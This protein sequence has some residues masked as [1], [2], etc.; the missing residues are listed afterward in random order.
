[1]CLLGLFSLSVL[2]ALT[3]VKPQSGQGYTVSGNP[4]GQ[5]L[6]P[7]EGGRSLFPS[8]LAMR[9]IGPRRDEGEVEEKGITVALGGGV[10]LEL[11][12]IPAGVFVMGS[13]ESEEGRDKDEGP[14][15]W[16]EITRP[17]YLGRYEVT[18]EQ[19]RKVM[20]HNP[21]GFSPTGQ[22][23]IEVPGMNTDHFPVESVSWDDAERFCDKL[24]ERDRHRRR[25]R[26]PT[27][28][29]W[30]YACRAGTSTPFH[31]GEQLN[32]KKANCDG[33]HPYGTERK[34]PR[35][36]RTT[37]VGSYR[38]N[39]W[40]LFDMH[41]NVQE[42][43]RDWYRSDS[44]QNRS[45]QDPRGPRTGRCRVLRGGSWKRVAGGCRASCR[46]VCEPGSEVADV[47]FR[48]AFRPD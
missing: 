41:G 10:K 21:S 14:Q 43:C 6:F 1:V 5:R 19:Y 42:W 46:N 45:V 9:D 15:H 12:R 29:E 27:E 25:F 35:L 3:L 44:Y 37:A 38:A 33:R 24:A 13:P 20:G 39:A 40:G 18:Q 2:S 32:G 8:L 22:R 34:G 36:L 23:R 26:L 4:E 30:E 47:G 28:A 17:F 48:V 11:V 7:R 16:V 31:F